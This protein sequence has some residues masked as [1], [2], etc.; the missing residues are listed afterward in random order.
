MKKI[1]IASAA[2]L[3]TMGITSSA[4]AADMAAPRIYKAPVIVCSWCG[5]YAGVNLGADWGHSEVNFAP[6]GFFLQ[7]P[8]AQFFSGVGSPT[9]NRSNFSGGGQIGLNSQ[10]LNFL[11][12]LEVDINYI[13]F[14]QSRTATFTSPIAGPAGGTPEVF[15]F[16][17]NVRDNWV[18]TQRV[19][20][21]WA[22][23]TTLL[24]VTGGLAVSQHQF[25]AAYFSP[26]FGAGPAGLE[27]GFVANVAGIGSVSSRL[28]GGWTA[29]GGFEFKVGGGWSLRAEYLYIDLGKSQF[30]TVLVGNATG[31]A[32]PISSGFT[33]HHENH[34]WTNVARVG[35]NY[36]WGA[37]AAAIR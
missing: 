23:D 16:N 29:G 18:S 8:S 4:S 31:G 10:W 20:F 17:D 24:Y 25:S 37:L 32:G 2:L 13:G 5:F 7:D 19:R 21:G 36:Q 26:N 34:M 3:A 35:I 12:G 14:N 33:A 15:T 30:D 27:A 1:Y 22:T 28:V 6:R 9:F 11:V